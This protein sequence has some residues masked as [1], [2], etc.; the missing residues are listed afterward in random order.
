[1]LLEI[2]MITRNWYSI[3]YDTKTRDITGPAYLEPRHANSAQDQLCTFFNL[4]LP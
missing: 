1:M 2:F 4:E 3:D